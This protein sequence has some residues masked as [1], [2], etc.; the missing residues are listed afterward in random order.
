MVTHFMRR[1]IAKFKAMGEHALALNPHYNELLA[2][3]AV[4]SI[5]AGENIERGLA[6]AEK[7][8]A[9]SPSHP[10]WYHLAPFLVHY[11]KS[12]Y[13]EALAEANEVGMPEWYWSHVLRAMAHAQLGDEAGTKAAVEALSKVFPNF[14]AVARVEVDKHLYANPALA[15]AFLDGLDKAGLLA[16]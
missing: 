5:M 9:L 8:M 10:G 6:L 2:D 11:S 1:E 13:A 14:A 7:A 12:E 16:A 3:Y 4:H 15:Q